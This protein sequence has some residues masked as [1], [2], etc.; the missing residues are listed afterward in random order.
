[1][2]KIGQQRAL[3][4]AYKNHGYSCGICKKPITKGYKKIAV[5][6]N[7][8]LVALCDE[9]TGE[10]NE[11]M[12]DQPPDV[13]PD[14]LPQKPLEIDLSI[15]E[16]FHTKGSSSKKDIFDGFLSKLCGWSGIFGGPFK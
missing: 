1:M 12:P 10:K 14:E 5:K 11:Y 15:Y 3:W 7:P 2:S 6:G 8:V 16:V 9:C 4:W 13:F